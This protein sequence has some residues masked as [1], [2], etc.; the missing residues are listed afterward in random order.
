MHFDSNADT[1]LH[2]QFTN[3]DTRQTPTVFTFPA[4]YQR[5]RS[6]QSFDEI[7]RNGRFLAGMASHSSGDQIIFALNIGTRALPGNNVVQEPTYVRVLNWMGDHI[8]CQGLTGVCLITTY[9]DPSNGWQPLEGELFLQYTDGSVLR[10]AHHR[11]GECGY[12]VQPRA[13]LSRNGRYI[14]FA[15]DWAQETG[16]H[17]CNSSYE[18]GAGDAYVIDLQAGGEPPP[19]FSPIA[20]LYLPTVRH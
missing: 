4:G 8:S 1:T 14:V 17:S 10:L 2:L 6:K 3:V 12:W 5:I 16:Q 19:P 7:S 9:S 13:T 20:F 11:S 15:S 18:L